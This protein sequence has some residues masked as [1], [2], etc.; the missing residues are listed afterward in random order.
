MA[1]L[2]EKGIDFWK[3]IKQQDYVGLVEI[4]IKEDE[5]KDCKRIYYQNLIDTCNMRLENKIEIRLNE[6]IMIGSRKGVLVTQ[7]VNCSRK[8]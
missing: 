4:W 3:F 7:E 6:G 2:K 5:I 1:R 8:E